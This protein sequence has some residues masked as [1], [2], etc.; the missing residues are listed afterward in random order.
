MWAVV[1]CS[2]LVLA[3][4]GC[5]GYFGLLEFLGAVLGGLGCSELLLPGLGYSR[6][7]GDILGSILGQP[8][9]QK[10]HTTNL[11]SNVWAWAAFCAGVGPFLVLSVVPFLVLLPEP[12]FGPS[13][14]DP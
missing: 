14:S 11:T 8:K 6:K 3:T 13:Q 2:G 7:T 12:F 5:R 4:L 1:G 9:Q 10:A